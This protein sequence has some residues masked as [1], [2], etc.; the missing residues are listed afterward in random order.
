MPMY[1]IIPVKM[2]SAG[3]NNSIWRGP[4]LKKK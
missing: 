3:V 1:F 4:E 2:K